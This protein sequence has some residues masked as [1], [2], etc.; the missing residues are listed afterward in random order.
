M[1]YRTAVYW[2]VACVGF[3]GLVVPL[4]NVVAQC[5]GYCQSAGSCPATG[6]GCS[7]TVC[8]Y[9][10][11]TCQ[12]RVCSITTTSCTKPGGTGILA[13]RFADH[14]YN[15]YV[16][17]NCSYAYTQSTTNCPTSCPICIC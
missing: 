3:L 14:W 12:T 9:C 8:C 13:Y 10:C 6:Y 16:G 7:P 4:G 15:C 11:D 1:R 2:L 17:A 5:G